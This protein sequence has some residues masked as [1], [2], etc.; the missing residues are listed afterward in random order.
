MPLN[1]GPSTKPSV[2]A[3]G[4][5]T[6]EPAPDPAPAPRR[7]SLGELFRR[8]L[9]EDFV[10]FVA[11]EKD[12]LRARCLLLTGHEEY[13]DTLRR[14]LLASVALRWQWWRPRAARTRDQ[15]ARVM[16][17]RGLRREQ[18][19]W[20][21]ERD[22]PGLGE[23]PRGQRSRRSGTADAGAGRM[24]VMPTDALPERPDRSA[25]DLAA[26]A[27]SRARQIRRTRTAAASAALVCVVILAV[28]S[29]RLIRQ[30][31]P[32][33]VGPSAVPT[34]VLLMPGYDQL[35]TLPVRAVSLPANFDIGTDAVPLAPTALRDKPAP[36][37]LALLQHAG[38]MIYA[39]TPDGTVRLIDNPELSTPATQ[40]YP[41]SL[42]PDGLRAVF[43]AAT[44]VYVLDI[45]TGKVREIDSGG[46]PAQLTWRGNRTLIVPNFT[47]ALQIDI[48]TGAVGA[49]A[50]TNGSDVVAQ[51]GQKPTAPM[52]ELIPAPNSPRMR[53]WRTE[54][55]TTT[56]PISSSPAVTDVE[57]RPI[58]GP[59]W[60]GRWTGPGFANG[61]LVVRGCG[62]ETIPLPAK[63]GT[64]H[65]AVGALATNGLYVA[66][67]VGTDATTLDVIGMAD[68][69]TVLLNATGP[70]SS[71]VLAW[72]P[73]QGVLQRVSS[74]SRTVV[75]S[76]V[77]AS[78]TLAN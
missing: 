4:P 37:A 31:P 24:R 63:N 40:L 69:Q 16:L 51:Q 65:S 17:A 6:D 73:Q 9:P 50:T 28:L 61:D 34:G 42:S 46:P 74:I 45:T 38:G 14:D 29:P 7:W 60:I 8:G 2:D 19:A 70:K 53:V 77:D 49:I 55:V 72:A 12:D 35:A 20:P 13:A 39:F 21:T 66:T 52:L 41:T 62:P 36:R 32:K 18:R 56:D 5:S 30:I 47:T 48:D 3:G 67:L 44:G 54:P 10:A 64:A 25:T 26:L 71:T 11:A 57:D 1:T 75:L 76:I 23:A 33:A 58:F 43:P 15:L 27:W 68:A 59:P 22:R 78:S